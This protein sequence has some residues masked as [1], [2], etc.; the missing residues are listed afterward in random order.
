MA[1]GESRV[2]V[3]RARASVMLAVEVARDEHGRKLSRLFEAVR[4]GGPDQR[5]AAS[6]AR[7][8]SE[9]LF[10]GEAGR[11]RS[12]RLLDFLADPRAELEHELT[13]E[14]GGE[15]AARDGAWGEVPEACAERDARPR[16]G[17]GGGEGGG[18]AAAGGR[19]AGG[20]AA[21]DEAGDE[22]GWYLDEVFGE[23]WEAKVRRL[24]AESPHG[25]KAGWAL[26]PLISKANDDVRQEVFVMQIV[27]LIAEAMPAP[28]ATALRPYAEIA[29]YL[30]S[31]PGFL[32]AA[33]TLRVGTAS[34]RRGPTP[35]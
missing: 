31:R 26:L 14:A 19:G 17:G 27:K 4:P 2:F 18:G 12:S 33:G 6:V 32:M 25:R 7:A 35:G 29:A 20:G 1:P 28:L 13:D 21:T 9:D 22:A 10:A 23:A 16:S 24:R 8:L 3:T 15:L 30:G 34:W 11:D 5:R